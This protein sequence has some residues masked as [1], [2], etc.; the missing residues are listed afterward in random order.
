MVDAVSGMVSGTMVS[1]PFSRPA[2][3]STRASSA[4]ERS[5]GMI[6][7][8]HPAA[9][10]IPTASSILGSARSA[11][12]TRINPTTRPMNPPSTMPYLC[13]MPFLD[14]ELGTLTMAT[15][16]AAMAGVSGTLLATARATA[17]APATACCGVG[18]L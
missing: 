15:D 11:A 13:S 3:A 2:S 4:K 9:P 5:L 16:P 17:S 8:R 14:A 7:A 18:A 10:A 1:L 6:A 12:S